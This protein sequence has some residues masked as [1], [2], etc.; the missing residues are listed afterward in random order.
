LPLLAKNYRGVSLREL[1]L[2]AIW[3]DPL[4]AARG[5]L[6]KPTSSD[7]RASG[8]WLTVR[9]SLSRSLLVVQGWILVP[10]S[11]LRGAVP[12]SS[13]ITNV[14]AA[15]RLVASLFVCALSHCA[16]LSEALFGARFYR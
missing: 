9:Q 10:G 8:G 15:W 16:P 4:A 7:A 2:S 3:F 1:V 6:G 13:Y 14:D 5:A 12:S 11:I